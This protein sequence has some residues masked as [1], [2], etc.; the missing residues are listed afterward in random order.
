MTT[1]ISANM[2]ILLYFLVLWSAVIKEANA[3][4]PGQT[5]IPS[6]T[7]AFVSKES[8]SDWDDSLP[9]DGEY[10]DE[11]DNDS[12]EDLLDI[13]EEYYNTPR[14]DDDDLKVKDEDFQYER[15]S[16]KST[17]FGTDKGD[18]SGDSNKQVLYDAYN[19]L[20][21]LA[22]VRLMFNNGSFHLLLSLTITR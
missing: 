22:Q 19:Q 1:R 3:T 5:G 2:K 11:S 15:P 20:H 21:V 8:N 18:L 9:D 17:V 13:D 6:T 4:K 10:G 12:D 14:V 16:F 7:R